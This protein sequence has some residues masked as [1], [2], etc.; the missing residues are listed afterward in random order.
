MSET[1]GYSGHEGYSGLSGYSGRWGYSGYSGREGGTGSGL[2]GYSG[3]S[4][5]SGYVGFIGHS[6]YSGFS[7]RS[8]YSGNE[9]YSGLSGYSGH[10]GFSG[11]SGVE[12][13]YSASGYSGSRGGPGTSGYS[14]VRGYDGLSGY[15]GLGLSGYSGY[16]GQGL[17]GYSGLVGSSGYS[18]QTGSFEGDATQIQLGH[19]SSGDWSTGIGGFSDSTSVTN[20]V[21]VLDDIVSLIAPTKPGIF[22]GTD[23]SYTGTTKYTVRLSDG[24]DSWWYDDGAVPGEIITDYI[25]DNSFR[26][27]TPDIT[28]KFYCGFYNNPGGLLELYR[29]DL[30]LDS[31][32]TS[33]GVGTSDEIT[34]NDFTTYNNIW[35]K[36]NAYADITQSLDGYR[37]YYFKHPLSGQTNII[38]FR[39]D[40]SNPA[41]S[42]GY[43]PVITEHTL[44]AKYL[45]GITYYGNGTILNASFNANNLYN[46]AYNA[47]QLAI[48]SVYPAA[49]STY[50]VVSPTSAPNYTDV[51]TVTNQ[52]MSLNIANMAS[53]SP[54]V[55][56]TLFKANGATIYS[57]VAL[58]RRVCTYG[59]V[60]TNTTEPFYDEAYRL[61]LGT[62][63]LWNSML[64]LSNGNAQVRN[65]T[66]MYPDSSDYPGFSN[67][68][69]YERW[70]YK[71]SASTGTLVFSGISYIDI[72]PQDTG[73]L[74]VLLI[75]DTD[76]V[77]FDL[78]KPVGDGNGCRVSGS[79]GSAI[80]SFGTY[81][82]AN[83]NN[84]YR[85]KI[86]FRNRN[87]TISNIVA[88]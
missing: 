38:S 39:Y 57:D 28:T 64:A 73:D 75:L 82:T 25:L 44:V 37:S 32:D 78:G 69:S 60:S 15:S 6:G 10:F 24:L 33:L 86:T 1:S 31:Y 14:G 17:S 9:G 55:R 88:S 80:F 85:I 87:H 53:N 84:R 63:A 30:V 50:T 2:S 46:K 7:G 58:V 27:I 11:Y 48:I 71:T 12:G 81:S 70:L 35:K 8:S 56:V 76:G 72:D 77:T 40:S 52:Q 5:Y 43:G 49:A 61:V 59:N 68:Q 29:D 20:A 42:F 47:T 18:G 22:T 23:I 62:G 26:L 21:H 79:G 41:A 83:N 4:G 34:L 13:A 16:S 36:A 66:L 51:L 3:K 45:S 74:N 67:N 65:G 54:Y 19:P